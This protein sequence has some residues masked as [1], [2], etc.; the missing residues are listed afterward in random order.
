M[1]S[2]KLL[3]GFHENRTAFSP[4]DTILGA[5]LWQLDRAP[6]G[7]EA[8]LLWFTRGK[9]TV[10]SS[11]I[12]TLTFDLPQA[13]DTRTFEWIAPEEP[14]SFSGR[15]IAVIWA[16]E[17]VINGGKLSERAEITI[18]PGGREIVLDDGS[19]SVSKQAS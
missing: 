9:G 13:N 7:A 11:I 10:D 17:L 19:P 18:A 14:Y 3:V 5:V 6:R 2:S 4:G 1:S 12:Q 8:N 16:V 15:L